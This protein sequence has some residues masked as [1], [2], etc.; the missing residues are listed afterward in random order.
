[1]TPRVVKF[2]LIALAVCFST[3][4]ASAQERTLS[5][6]DSHP[7][8]I[9]PDARSAFKKGE[10]ERV[11]QLCNWYH[12]IQGCKAGEIEANAERCAHLL[13]EMKA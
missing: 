2:F 8:E 1:M 6:Y 12:T 3:F 4:L 5:Y 9:L 10:Y 13:S 11:L 7:S